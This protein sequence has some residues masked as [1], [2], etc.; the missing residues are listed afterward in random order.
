MSKYNND[1]I[2]EAFQRKMPPGNLV[3]TVI[4]K[5]ED[6]GMSD[7]NNTPVMGFSKK[8]DAVYAVEHLN[9]RMK[10]IGS[11]QTY[12]VDSLNIF[13]EQYYK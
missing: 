13:H 1:P 10:E 5:N 4:T 8:E 11:K 12:K 3:Y 7:I 2:K 6:P 9:K